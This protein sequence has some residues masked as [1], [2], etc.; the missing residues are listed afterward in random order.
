MAALFCR[1]PGGWWAGAFRW[2]TL[3]CSIQLVPVVRLSRVTPERVISWNLD[4]DDPDAVRVLDVHLGQAPRLGGRLPYDR[5][6][7]RGQPG[8][9]GVHIA[10]LDPDHHRAPG[11]PG[12]VAGDLE[13]SLAEEE[14]QPGI[15]RRAELPV[16][17]QAEQVAVEAAAA[18]QIAG[19]QQDPAAQN[20]HATI[21]ASRSATRKAE[22]NARSAAVIGASG[23][24]QVPDAL[25]RIAASSVLGQVTSMHRFAAYPGTTRMP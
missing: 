8:V 11:R 21:P 2:S 16:D 1:I 12:R 3:H 6:S 15:V 24:R 7:G 22:E 14:H 10:D 5:A 18:V 17:G 4:Q 19:A 9:L 13:Q 25:T 23:S 20:I